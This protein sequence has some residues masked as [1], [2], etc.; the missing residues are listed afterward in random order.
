MDLKVSNIKL[1][2]S[3]LIV[4]GKTT[5]PKARMRL[6]ENYYGGA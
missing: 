4:A 3:G 1:L 2:N 5:P 6:K